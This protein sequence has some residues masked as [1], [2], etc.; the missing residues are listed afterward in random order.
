[1]INLPI[2]FRNREG[3]SFADGSL[4]VFFM[5]LFF[6]LFVLTQS[7]AMRVLKNLIEL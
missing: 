6:T 1:M 2:V 7:H 3:V 5:F 4:L